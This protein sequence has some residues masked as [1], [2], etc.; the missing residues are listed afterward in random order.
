MLRL[1][2]VVLT[3]VSHF[4]FAETPTI[5]SLRS[6]YVQ[7]ISDRD[8]TAVI[9]LS[10][11]QYI[12][13]QGSLVFDSYRVRQVQ[14]NYVLIE[15]DSAVIKLFLLPD[16]PDS[17]R[18]PEIFYRQLTEEPIYQA[19]PQQQDNMYQGEMK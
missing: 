16:S 9:Y 14:S 3:F 11:N 18:P 1:L 12:A 15:S 13:K 7:S 10:G 2:L 6:A 17:K 8:A 4:S 19:I 5:D